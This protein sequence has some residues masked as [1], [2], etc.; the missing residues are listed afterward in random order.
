M[1]N[2]IFNI[3]IVDSNNS[4][5]ANTQVHCVTNGQSYTTN[6]SGQ[7]PQTIETDPDIKSLQFTWSTSGTGS[8]TTTDGSLQQRS[9]IINNYTGTVTISSGNSFSG[10]CSTTVQIS[11]DGTSYRINASATVGNYIAVGGREYIIVQVDS[12]IVYVILRYWEE[13]VQFDSG[14]STDYDNS[15]IMRKCSSWHQHAVPSVWRISA[16]ALTSVITEGVS[17]SCFV[18]TY[19]QIFNGGFSWFNS[20]RARIFTNSSGTEKSWWTSTIHYYNVETQIWCVNQQ[21]GQG[22]N[23]TATLSAGF[24]PAL[25]LKRSLFTS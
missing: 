16:N 7:I 8:W 10:N 2:N 20:N 1:P 23:Y 3:T 18:P 12:S 15:D 22:Y 5:V 25:A 4:P 6:S 19:N 24:R 13:N 17:A 9:N 11:S 14:G 21:G